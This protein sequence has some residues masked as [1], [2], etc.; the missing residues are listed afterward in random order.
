MRVNG[1]NRGQAQ[2]LLAKLKEEFKMSQRDVAKWCGV[3]NCVV[4]KWASGEYVASTQHLD[5]LREVPLLLAGRVIRY[6]KQALDILM[7]RE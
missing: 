2:V 6:P 7:G 5:K 1:E 3:N 4:S